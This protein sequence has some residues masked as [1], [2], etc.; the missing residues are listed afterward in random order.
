[1]S[2]LEEHQAF[3]SANQKPQ[4]R[5][6]LWIGLALGLVVLLAVAA[7]VGARQLLQQPSG[8]GSSPIIPGQGGDAD[9]QAI[10]ISVERSD[11]LPPSEP[12]A[13][14]IFDHREGNSIFVTSGGNIYISTGDDSSVAISGNSE[15]SAS[16][17]ST[18]EIVISQETEVYV[19]TTLSNANFEEGETQIELQQTLEPGDIEEIGENSIISAWGERRGERLIAE[20]VV[21]DNPTFNLPAP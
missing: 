5:T 10:G 7:F 8:E 9:S 12:E 18:I 4:K 21:Y 19:D 11:K 20:V 17:S 16:S 13:S 6:G 3:E 15:G 1:M 2:N 14:G